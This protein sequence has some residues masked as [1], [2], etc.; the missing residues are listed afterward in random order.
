MFDF[1]DSD[2]FVITLEIIFV[3][4]IVFDI[5]K[6]KETRKKEYITNIVLTIGFAIW[7]LYPMYKSYFGWQET[8]KVEMLSTCNSD[9]N[10][11]LCKQVDDAIF[12]NYTYEEYKVLD[13]NST[14][15][16]EFIK[17]TKEDILDDSWF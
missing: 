4:L 16:K 14:E 9:E 1:L 5:K 8:Q 15:F 10:Q 6:Y 3:I 7:T 13:K 12:K 2:W 11:T 17:E